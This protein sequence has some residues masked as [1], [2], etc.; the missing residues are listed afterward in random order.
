MPTRWIFG[1]RRRRCH[2]AAR[3]FIGVEA[4][5]INGVCIPPDMCLKIDE[6]AR[7]FM[8]VDVASVDSR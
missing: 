8:L 2:G 5:S 3:G 7:T 1:V 4:Q 6:G